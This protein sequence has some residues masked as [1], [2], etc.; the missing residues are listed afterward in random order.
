ME[1]PLKK[2]KKTTTTTKQL[3]LTIEPFLQPKISILGL[4]LP[5]MMKH[6]DQKQLGE[7]RVYLTHT[8]G[9]KVVTVHHGRKIGQELK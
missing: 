5:A 2:E 1:I 6:H 3:L 8:S 7:E 9:S 4:L